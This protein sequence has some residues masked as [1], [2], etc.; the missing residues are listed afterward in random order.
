VRSAGGKVLNLVD[1]AD[2][3][4]TFFLPTATAGRVQ[5]ATEVR[6][7]LDAAARTSVDVGA[8]PAANDFWRHASARDSRFAE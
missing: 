5:M 6:L 8:A 4:M 3:Y 1:L 2:A 7:V